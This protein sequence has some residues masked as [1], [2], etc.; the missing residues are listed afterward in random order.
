MRVRPDVV[1]IDRTFDYS[2][3]EGMTV[4]VGDVVRVRLANRT[5]RGWVVGVDVEPSGDYSI[6]PIGRRSGLGPSPELVELAT[7]AAWRWAGHPVHF[8]RAATPDANVDRL[9]AGISV[10]ALAAGSADPVVERALGE[11]T[12]VLRLPP[13]ADRYELVLSALRRTPGGGL[14]VLVPFKAQARRLAR[15][16]GAEG[17]P[18]ALVIGDA[19]AAGA[20]QWARARAG[21][22][23]IGTRSA[24]WAPMARLERVLVLDEHDEAFQ[25][26]Q[27]PTWNARDV[28]VERARRAASPCLLVSS[29]PSLEALAS[30]PVIDLRGAGRR[31]GWPRIEVV[32]Q[33]EADPADGPLF[34][35]A[36][37]RMLRREGRFLCI[38][39]R[40]GRVRLLACS[41]CR[42]LASCAD[43]GG[44]V[45]SSSGADG[46]ETFVCN[47]DPDHRRPVVCLECGATGFRNLRLG[48]SRARE[49]LE[50]LLGEP[51]GEVTAASGAPVSA[52]RVLVG[53][54]A[55]LHSFDRVAGVAFLDLD[56]H[57]SAHRYRAAEE[58]F[59]MLG[60]A[61]RI[62][63]RGG[64]VLLAQTR[65]PDHPV[66]EAL[67]ARDPD[68]FS[69]P[70]ARLRATLGLPPSTALALVSGAGAAT[71]VDSLAGVEGL[72]VQGPREGTWR[73]RAADHDS[74]CDALAQVRRPAERLRVEVDP[75]RA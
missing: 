14:L 2:L 10:R 72:S 47:R 23:V 15:R 26:D 45:S 57:L 16:L 21:A 28:A 4:G 44:S 70:E 36:L 51:V 67:L 60:T 68:R 74:L 32:D 38:L 18:V 20:G 13:G 11:Q 39:D 69:G 19:G 56:Q 30:A 43:C 54:S 42:S 59:A 17:I 66:L 22:V 1:G 8:L 9:P 46:L 29:T 55:L 37:V 31:A 52:T 25:G 58:A 65:M 48:V 63:A 49:E 71:F 34:S 41:S 3:P 75:L 6:V 7:W 61:A 33:R 24:A 12:A 73:V 64:G 62:A 40:T 5:V 50:A 35:A 53:T 27:T